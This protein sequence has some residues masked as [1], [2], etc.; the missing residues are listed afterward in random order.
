MF[1][2]VTISIQE[3]IQHMKKITI[4]IVGATLSGKTALLYSFK[5]EPPES[6]VTTIGVDFAFSHYPNLT[7]NWV[8]LCGHQR[9][10]FTFD[11]FFKTFDAVILMHNPMENTIEDTQFWLN[12]IESFKSKPPCLLLVNP[13]KF[14]QHLDRIPEENKLISKHGKLLELKISDMGDKLPRCI[15]SKLFP[16]IKLA[17][18][19]NSRSSVYSNSF[20]GNFFTHETPKATIQQQ[21]R[22]HLNIN[23]SAVLNMLSEYKDKQQNQLFLNELI[24]NLERRKFNSLGEII[25]QLNKHSESFEPHPL[26]LQLETLYPAIELTSPRC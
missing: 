25:Q 23:F 8:E 2:E 20:K 12:H 24:D 1:R 15:M 21:R 10:M 6:A 19:R 4:G 16:D 22:M 18:P 7:I 13:Y 14:S 5:G 9:F 26:S 17:P 11:A 3:E